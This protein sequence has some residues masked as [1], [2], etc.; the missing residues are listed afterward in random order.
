MRLKIILSAG[1]RVGR[2]YVATMCSVVGLLAIAFSQTTDTVQSQAAEVSAFSSSSYLDTIHRWTKT[3]PSEMPTTS[4]LALPTSHER[5]TLK[6]CVDIAIR[7]NLR[8]INS[9]R[10]VQIAYSS[11]RAAKGFF[12]PYIELVT[13]VNAATERTRLLTGEHT[14]AHS[15]ALEGT[16]N[17]GQNLP[18]GGSLTGATDVSRSKDD[19]RT[20]ASSAVIEFSQPLWRGGGLDVGLADLKQSKLNRISEE[21]R[22]HLDQR[23]VALS[24]VSQFF[25]ILRAQMDLLVSED[26]IWVKKEALRGAEIKLELGQIPPSEKSKAEIQY[27]QEEEN[28]VTLRQRYQDEL[29]SMLLLLGLPLETPFGVDT[30]TTD[31]LVSLI[32]AEKQLIPDL[33]TCIRE[34]R[35]NRMELLLNDISLRSSEIAL[36]VARNNIYPDLNFT[37]GGS[38]SDSDEELDSAV[39][40]SDHNTWDVGLSMAIPFPNIER[41]ESYR[42][43]LINLEKVKTS[44]LSAERDIVQEV[45]NA[46]RAVQSIEV[47]IPILQKTVE[48]ATLSLEQEN[49]RF[50]YGLNTITDIRNAQD[51][52]FGARTRYY[53]ALLNY[54]KSVADLYKAIGRRIF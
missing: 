29:E 53:G 25:D 13:S 8:L 35:S 19:T 50:E 15:N 38:T 10:D 52:L 34:A 6:Q 11:Y 31:S 44:N 36:A 51:D 39:S 41:R 37:A 7:S 16:L 2:I 32:H 46:Y 20:Y 17:A 54:Q 14:I 45:K 4:A 3:T 28:L 40:A 12:I 27:L 48:Q 33:E 1:N 49:A 24:V 26:A 5:L 22:N 30:L 42:R 23:D 18:T 47:N 9:E 43:T 21:I